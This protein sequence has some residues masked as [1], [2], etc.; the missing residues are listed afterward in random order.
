MAVG[1]VWRTALASIAAAATD[2]SL[3]DFRA[4]VR[5]WLEPRWPR[6]D[7][8]LDDPREDTIARVGADHEGFVARAR[9]FQGEL[10]AAG[11]A[12]VTVPVSLGGRGLSPA[13]KE[14][15]DEELAA[16][17]TPSLRPLG[18][19]LSLA[20]PT[21]LRAGSEEH[22]QRYIPPLLAGREQWC[23]LFSEPGAGSDL[24]SL[25]TT[26]RADGDCW[27]VDGQKVWSSYAHDADFGILLA[28][29]DLEAPKPQAGMTMFILG[30]R[31]PGV[32]VRPLTDITGSRHFNEVWLDQV[33]IPA[34]A[35]LGR[36]H[37]GWDVANGTLGGER[38][39]Y[40]GGSGGGRRQRQATAALGSRR[41]DLVARQ[42]VVGL[43]IR[44]R[45][46]EWLSERTRSGTLAGGHPAA[47]SLVKLAAGNLEQAAAETIVELTGPASLAWA[48]GGDGDRVA[49]DL[50]AS[51]Q[52]TLAGGTHQIQRNLLAE[53]VLGLPREP[54]PA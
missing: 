14:V 4:E 25:R 38:G 23:Q 15:L 28:R 27:V 52:A 10:H 22:K 30:M 19:G 9:A 39:G 51:R 50:A 34:E 32:T 47:G 37:G 20:G 46:L 8:A 48:S 29:T 12:G 40:L 6:R 44:E 36:L 26:A 7:P 1:Q 17:D 24:A 54:R 43:V 11:L 33:A 53:R 18:I 45:I 5:Q 21:I 49:F 2:I 31:S 41:G 3:D 42:Q 13:H 35:I 16:F